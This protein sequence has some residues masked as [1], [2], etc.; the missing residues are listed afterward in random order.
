MDP[1]Y[2]VIGIF[3]TAVL[4][5]WQGIKY[6]E[7]RTLEAEKKKVSDREYS[8]EFARRWALGQKF[9]S[10][11]YGIIGVD[12]KKYFCHKYGCIMITMSWQED[13]PVINIY[14]V[15]TV[16]DA[17]FMDALHMPRCGNLDWMVCMVGVDI[18]HE[19]I[20][21]RQV[22]QLGYGIERAVHLQTSDPAWLGLFDGVFKAEGN[23]ETVDPIDLMHNA[24][25]VRQHMRL[26]TIDIDGTPVVTALDAI[27]DN[28]TITAQVVPDTAP[29]PP[30]WWP[31]QLTS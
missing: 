13:V 16:Q 18:L 10:T 26:R 23:R 20:Q 28:K 31:T 25:A 6:R 24:W 9:F 17:W 4:A 8:E 22:L 12:A 14:L 15:D 1:L 29:K 2:Y 3:A 5:A 30:T 21:P 19:Y 7:K 11:G 27:L